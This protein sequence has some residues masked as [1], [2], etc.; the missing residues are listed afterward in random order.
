[1]ATESKDDIDTK[2]DDRI[3]VEKIM[4]R[5]ENTGYYEW[6]IEDKSLIANILNAKNNQK[7]MSPQFIASHL[8][9]RLQ[10]YPNGSTESTKGSVKAYLELVS[11]PATL[12]RISVSFTLFFV[13]S[14][15]S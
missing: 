12:E 8:K 13:M 15:K 11:L 4:Y 14:L 5:G 1:M 7:F 6:K 3:D 10:L 2:E 9:W